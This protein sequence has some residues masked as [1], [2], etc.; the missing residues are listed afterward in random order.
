MIGGRRHR[1]RLRERVAP[2]PNLRPH[3]HHRALYHGLHHDRFHDCRHPPLPGQQ[4]PGRG[5]DPIVCPPRRHRRPGTPLYPPK[6][7]LNNQHYF[8]RFIYC[9]VKH[10]GRLPKMFC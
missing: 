2:H 5:A 7:S 9:V 8:P 6:L 3:P 1:G 4:L 10:L